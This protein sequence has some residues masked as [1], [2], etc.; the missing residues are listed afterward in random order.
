ML[1]LRLKHHLQTGNL[2]VFGL[3]SGEIELFTVKNICPLSFTPLLLQ[4]NWK[5]YG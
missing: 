5:F 3:K 2:I 1:L 4:P